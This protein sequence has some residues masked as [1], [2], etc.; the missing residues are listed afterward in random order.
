MRVNEN[1]AALSM[2]QILFKDRSMINSNQ[3]IKISK[4]EE[5]ARSFAINE[6][7][8][9]Q[10][11]DFV[12]AEGNSC[13]EETSLNEAITTMQD[14]TG[15]LEDMQ[16]ILQTIQDKM[17]LNDDY[18][19][20][21]TRYT[22]LINNFDDVSNS[23][24]FDSKW[25]KNGLMLNREITSSYFNTCD[26][27][28][29]KELARSYQSKIDELE[30]INHKFKK[31]IDTGQGQVNEANFNAAKYHVQNIATAE[32]IVGKTKKMLLH[33]TKEAMLSQA[34]QKPEQ[35]ISLLE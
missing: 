18:N 20:V 13:D 4:V 31:E 8:E 23:E 19:V 34:N 7:M 25:F 14:I 12:K 9:S 5:D 1:V 6:K 26:I 10:I 32:E 27:D 21:S 24:I 16:E 28:Q 17:S 3:K 30:G 15:I 33:E 35:V 2:Q 11:R 29:I 22:E